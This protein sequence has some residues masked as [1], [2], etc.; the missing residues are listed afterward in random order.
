MSNTGFRKTPARPSRS[1]FSGNT[2]VVHKAHAIVTAILPTLATL[3]AIVAI[4][5]GRAEPWQIAMLL[6]SYFLTTLSIT[7]GYHRLL[8]HRAFQTTSPIKIALVIIACTAGQ[9]PP[10]YWVTNHRQHHRYTDRDGDPH[11]PINRNGSPLGAW[12]G[13]WHSQIGWTFTHAPSN[14]L[15]Y[16]PDLLK[17]KAVGWVG[18]H[19]LTWLMLGLIFPAS[20]GFY[21]DNSLNGFAQGLLWGGFVRMFITNQLTNAINSIAHMWGYQRYKMNNESRNNFVLGLLTLGEGWHNN[22][23]H[24]GSHAI[25]SRAWYEIDIGGAFIVLLMCLGLAHNVRGLKKHP[26]I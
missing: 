25:F 11:S 10:I 4:C 23:H 15:Q 22:H 16:S 8:T 26:E 12:T 20:I 3:Y 17:D 5:I 18:R 24:E 9:G 7:V 21:L 2:N 19:Y 1:R 14:S 13:F 6:G